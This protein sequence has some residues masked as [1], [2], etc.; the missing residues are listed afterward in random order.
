MNRFAFC[1]G[2]ILGVS[3]KKLHAMV[4]TT[5]PRATALACDELIEPILVHSSHAELTLKATA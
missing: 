3:H 5:E 4:L 1:D 2:K